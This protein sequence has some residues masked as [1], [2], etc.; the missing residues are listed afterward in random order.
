MY[1]IVASRKF[2]QQLK[3]IIKAGQ[4]DISKIEQVINL[5][6]REIRLP[7]RYFDHQ[8]KGK[9]QNFRECHVA[10]DW[11]LI[12]RRHED[13]LILE[14]IATGSHTGLFE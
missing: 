5:L 10:P 2:R 12:Y 11:L 7:P 6:Q 4:D 13:L 14:L 3:K 9:L 8:L 1:A